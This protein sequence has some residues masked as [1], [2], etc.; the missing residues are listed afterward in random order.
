M[1]YLWHFLQTINFTRLSEGSGVP[2]LPSD[3]FNRIK[4]PN[5]NPEKQKQIAD[6]LDLAIEEINNK[7]INLYYLKSRN[8]G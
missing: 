2:S 7:K 6:C 5:H 1:N 3:V 4:I 8:V